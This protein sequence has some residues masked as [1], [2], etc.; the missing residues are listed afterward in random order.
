LAA[1]WRNRASTWMSH[2]VEGL[3]KPCF[4]E[5]GDEKQNGMLV[6]DI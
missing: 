4:G 6:K 5:G 3:K 2:H 1:S